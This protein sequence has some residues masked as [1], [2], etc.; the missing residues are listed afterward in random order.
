MDFSKE[1][2]LQFW[3]E[4]GYHETWD[5]YR[6]DWSGTIHSLIKQEIDKRTDVVTLEIGCGAGYWTKFL[7]EN[8]KLVY[9]IDLIPSLDLPYG[10]LTYIENSSKQFNCNR[11]ESESIDFVFSFG[12]FCH[13]SQKACESYVKDIFRVLKTG[14]SAILM[15][16]DDKSLQ[17]FHNNDEIKASSIFGESNDY[18]DIMPM[19]KKY[20]KN[21]TKL[22]DYRD[23][24]V[25]LNK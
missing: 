6:H 19:L 7:C 21:A 1:Q 13:F 8:S 3:S 24:L 12:V 18:A 5:G 17:K 23:A 9:A 15:F 4:K 16:S 25:L 20:D 10:N 22:L 14:G 2:F 11:I